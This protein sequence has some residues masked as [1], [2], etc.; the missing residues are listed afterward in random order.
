MKEILA[1]QKQKKSRPRRMNNSIGSGLSYNNVQFFITFR[2]LHK[3][4]N[5]NNKVNSLFTLEFSRTW[6]LFS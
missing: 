3:M 4:Y 1:L 6:T 5:Y 2:K